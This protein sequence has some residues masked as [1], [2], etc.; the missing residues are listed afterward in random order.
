MNPILSAPKPDACHFRVNP[1]VRVQI[2]A[3]YKMLA[4]N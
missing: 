1:E 2:E 4:V 3:V